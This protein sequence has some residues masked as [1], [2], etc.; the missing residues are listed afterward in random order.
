[1]DVREAW[2]SF[3]TKRGSLEPLPGSS[4]YALVGKAPKLER[5][6]FRRLES[7]GLVSTAF[8]RFNDLQLQVGGSIG[9]RVYFAAQLSA[10]NPIFMRDPNAL[11]GDNG[12]DMP[13]NPDPKLHSGFPILYHAEV[14]ELEPD[15]RFEYGG[16]LGLRLL[17]ADQGRGIDVMGFYYKTRLSEAAKL[18]GTFYEGDLDILNGAGDLSLPSRATTARS[19]GSTSTRAWAASRSSRQIVKEEAAGLPRLGIE[20]EAG[21][22]FA[23]GDL[24]DPGDLFPAIQPAVRW[25]RLDNDFTAPRGFVAPSF[26]WDWDKLDLGSARDDHPQARPDARVLVPRHRRLSRDPPRRGA[27]DAAAR[28]LAQR[29]A[30]GLAAREPLAG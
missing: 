23:L 9:T 24:A 13:P 20:V 15:D 17:S 5:Q 19:T 26:A 7:Y 4:L 8:N 2:I 18:R 22:R 6:P 29:V 14:E 30:H 28:V 10:G 16:A 11:A 1:M 3:G 12:T 25:S 21:Y 27:R